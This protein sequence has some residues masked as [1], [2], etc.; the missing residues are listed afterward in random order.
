MTHLVELC[1]DNEGYRIYDPGNQGSSAWLHG[2]LNENFAVI[3]VTIDEAA[4]FDRSALLSEDLDSVEEHFYCPTG[5]LLLCVA[6]YLPQEPP[7]FEGTT[8]C[9]RMDVPSG[10][11]ILRV[12]RL[13][14]SAS[15]ASQPF[16]F[17]RLNWVMSVLGLAVFLLSLALLLV[18]TLL[19]CLQ[20]LTGLILVSSLEDLL[21]LFLISL[22]A[23]FLSICIFN[24]LLNFFE[25]LDRVKQRRQEAKNIRLTRPDFWIQVETKSESDGIQA[26]P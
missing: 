21:L 12:F 11:H 16:Y 7:K 25:K 26:T 19:H 10:I 3:L 4:T 24:L 18:G 9:L 13:T 8:R 20:L 5:C 2:A 6:H 22:L 23:G 14:W 17:E 1:S 15:P